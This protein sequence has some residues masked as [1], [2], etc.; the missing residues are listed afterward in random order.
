MLFKTCHIDTSKGKFQIN[1]NKGELTC[2]VLL[3]MLMYIA[4]KTV[5]YLFFSL[6]GGGGGQE[7]SHNLWDLSSLTRDWIL[8]GP[9]HWKSAWSPSH[10]ASRNSLYLLIHKEKKCYMRDW[11]CGLYRETKIVCEN[12]HLSEQWASCCLGREILYKFYPSSLNSITSVSKAKNI[13]WRVLL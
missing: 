11:K 7:G 3:K 1:Q 8:P 4:I 13:S 10:W 2:S 5:P 9:W 6:W 12:G